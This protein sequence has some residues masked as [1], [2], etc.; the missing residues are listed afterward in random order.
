MIPRF[1]PDNA[2]FFLAGGLNDS[3]LAD[4]VTR[5]NLEAEIE[6]LYEF[7]ARRFMVALL[8]TKVP[9]FTPVA[10]RL[11][12]QLAKIPAEE[13]A[14]HPDIRIANSDWGPF[15]DEVLTH[16]AKY[17]ITNT[18]TECAQRTYTDKPAAECPTPDTHFYYHDSHPS[19][20]AHR[21]VGEMLYREAI[22]KAP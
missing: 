12:P 21:A 13:R 3:A 14:R 17:G 8:P 18:T 7:G 20:A 10:V 11:N 9:V 16:P 19:T 4:G 2:M 5:A 6:T 22:A 1:D 15:F